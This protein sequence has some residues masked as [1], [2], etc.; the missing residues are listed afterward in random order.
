MKKYI[1]II[2][3]MLA[4]TSCSKFLDVKPESQV[5]ADQLFS[6]EEGFKEALNGVYTYCASQALY[7]GNL[8]F[9]ML[10]ILGQNYEFSDSNLQISRSIANFDYSQTSTVNT[11][12]QI[13]GSGYRGIANCNYI[14]GAIDQHKALFTGNN[15]ALIKGE[16]LTVRAYLHFDLLRMFA[17]SYKNGATLKGIPYVTEIST[18]SAP[19]S[20]V[21]VAL[22]S[23]IADLT[24]AKALLKT[25]D[26]ILSTSYVV[27]YPAPADTKSTETTNSDLFLQ[28]RRHRMNYYTVCGE[29]ARA[30]L[31]KNDLVNALANAQEVIN[32]QK[33]PFTDS[34]DFLST[35]VTLVDR[36]FYK[37]L[38]SAW[39][40]DNNDINN[41]LIGLF[42]GDNPSLSATVDQVNDIYEKAQAGSEDWR[43]RQWFLS[44][45]PGNNSPNRA[46]LQK[47][48][49]NTSP[50]TNLHP[51]V[52][53]AIRL[54]EM[55]YIAAE[56]SFDTNPTQ[57]LA[58]FNT[59]R[60]KRGIGSYTVANVTDRNTF[61][62]LLLTDARKEFYGESQ[63]FFMYKR[64][65]HAVTIS[66]TQVQ[67]PSNQI[68]VFPLPNDE[69]AYR[70][71]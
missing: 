57:A 61:I 47:Y 5:D 67:P 27:G 10:D 33:F 18:K 68:F 69:L 1:Y 62:D 53:P 40:I 25:S 50:S 66:V 11:I 59:L 26:P 71:N 23:I 46:I 4:L 58:Y 17:P 51:L 63:I 20:T 35:D 6:T 44:R 34:K 9:G 49:K 64:L 70:N 43:L 31:Y 38:I 54:S 8:T 15:Y 42:T 24:A 3:T 65:N 22:N 12:A 7:G 28:N 30:Y 2:V 36:I 37:E 45:S 21:S 29:L 48:I 16:A 32:S 13:W 14:L 56:A 55:Y 41:E 60:Q 19:F 39:Y 52:A